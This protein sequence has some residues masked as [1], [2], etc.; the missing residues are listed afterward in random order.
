VKASYRPLGL[1]R[2]VAQFYIDTYPDLYVRLDGWPQ[3]VPGESRVRLACAR[4]IR[5]RVV[6]GTGCEIDCRP[7][8]SGSTQLAIDLPSLR[9]HRRR[10]DLFR[11]TPQL[12]T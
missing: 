10:A 12:Q 1:R 3:R 4:E 11:S 6:V 7:L 2:R 8:S 5:S 9:T